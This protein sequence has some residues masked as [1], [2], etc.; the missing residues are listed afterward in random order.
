M[1]LQ[2]FNQEFAA[3]GLQT[4]D[5]TESTNMHWFGLAGRPSF[6]RD[7]I[8]ERLKRSLGSREMH[9][10]KYRVRDVSVGDFKFYL[11]STLAG[12]VLAGM[13]GRDP[14]ATGVAPSR[15]REYVIDDAN[16][17]PQS[18]TVVR[19][20]PN[21]KEKYIGARISKAVIELDASAT[22]MI[23][24]SVVASTAQPYVGAVG[25]L[26]TD[27]FFSNDGVVYKE[28]A[29]AA[30]A[31][32]NA[33]NQIFP[34]TLTI[35]LDQNASGYPGLGASG[36]SK[37]LAGDF[38]S[39][40][41]IKRLFETKTE[42]DKW[43]NLTRI[44][45]YVKLTADRTHGNPGVKPTLEFMINAADIE[46]WGREGEGGSP[47]EQNYDVIGNLISGGTKSSTAKLINNVT[48]YK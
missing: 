9:A 40:L 48:N 27:D 15:T 35:T 1:P 41:R 36:W 4:D 34:K 46:A 20:G 43:L 29:T 10:G 2:I 37:I 25:A 45:S 32:A 13:Y 30:S 7:P 38:V 6:D 17:L 3:F 11:N 28:A 44:F 23:T 33:T 14:A 31:K 42:R 19:F 12:I 47:V 18:I 5:T 16:I 8:D 26:A 21:V 22:A 24:I 39:M